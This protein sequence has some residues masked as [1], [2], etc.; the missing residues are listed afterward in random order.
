MNQST[1]N[2][3]GLRRSLNLPLIVFYGLGTILGAGIYVLVGKVAGSAG[4]LAPVSFLLAAVA[5]AA[6]A[7][8]YAELS[9]RYPLSAGEAVYI[10]HG[11][12]CSWLSIAAGMLIAFAGIV[13]SAAISR[14][15]VGY[16][17]VFVATPDWLAIVLL[18]LVLGLLA[19]WGIGQSVRFASVLTVIEIGGLA[20]VIV[21]GAPALATLPERLPEMAQL[22]RTGDVWPGVLFG[23]FLAFY[24]FLGF[25]DMVNVAEE[26]VDPRRILPFAILIVLAISTV[27]YVLV[28]LAAILMV[29]PAT[30]EASDAPLALVIETATGLKPVYISFIGMAAV[31]NGALI[32]I[33]MVSRIVYG[34]SRQGWFPPLLGQVNRVTRTPVLATV[35]VAIGIIVFALWLPLTAL[36]GATSFLIL[37]VFVL[38][39][40]SLVR[41]KH[42][43]E[44]GS[45]VATYPVWVPIFG[46]LVSL[47][48]LGVSLWYATV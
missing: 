21:A 46:A 11:L 31:V 17:Q 28:A 8:S 26:V 30:L 38:V 2:N 29:P 14:G 41:I 4:L 12:G 32:Q 24:A 43:E 22:A 10:Q 16:L 37:I 39:N 13:S 35:F 44:P 25:E 45:T 1:V 15:F 42:R 36:A 34:M 6:T 7:F 40:V 9:S 5:V 47:G 23:A 27:L 19:V 20:W 48:L 3:S 33:I 18:V